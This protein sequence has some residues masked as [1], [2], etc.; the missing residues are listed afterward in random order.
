M[1]AT[2]TMD[3]Y[4]AMPEPVKAD[5]EE[6]R[7]DNNLEDAWIVEG[8]FDEGVLHA[9]VYKRGPNGE[10]YLTPDGEDVER[11]PQTF[12]LRTPLPL[13]VQPYLA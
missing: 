10:T 9:I 6:W 8:T 12:P 3:A 1:S 13:S 4:D 7:K 5:F 11:E 2:L